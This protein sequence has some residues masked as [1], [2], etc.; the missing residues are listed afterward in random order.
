MLKSAGQAAEALKA[1]GG[2]DHAASDRE[3]YIREGIPYLVWAVRTAGGYRGSWMCEACSVR[4]EV[5]GE[6]ATPEAAIGLA[7]SSLFDHHMDLHLSGQRSLVC[8][9][10]RRTH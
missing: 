4:G 2:G 1:M 5:I 8:D 9:L 7:K 10:Q 6:A 3:E